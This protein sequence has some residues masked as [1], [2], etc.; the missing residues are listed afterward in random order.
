MKKSNVLNRR[1]WLQLGFGLAAGTATG[2]TTK[3]DPLPENCG[4]TVPMELG[5]F[6]PMKARTQPDTDKDL[7]HVQGQSGIAT[8]QVIEVFGKILDEDCK[9]VEGA[10]I[11]LWQANHFGK[12]NHEYNAEGKHDPNFQGWGQIVTQKD[13]TYRFKTVVPGLYAQRTRHIHFKVSRRGYHEIVTQLYFEGEERNATDRIFNN[14]THEEQKLVLRAIDKS[15]SI[16][17][18]PFDIHIKKINE[19]GIS[20]K[21]LAAYTGSYQLK[22]KGSPLEPL[23]QRL[24]GDGHDEFTIDVTNESHMLFMKMPFTPRME[25]SWKAKDSFDANEF[26]NMQLA[27]RRGND[28]KVNA[29]ALTWGDGEPIVATKV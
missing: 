18:L 20:D 14:L 25:V 23:I 7:T 13:G 15:Q 6:P 8:G 29:L 4:A 16:P 17:A 24:Y 1:K 27:F 21:V 12:Y 26:F 3:P 2:F 22:C 5:P 11:E 28:E 19:T 9:P 10:V